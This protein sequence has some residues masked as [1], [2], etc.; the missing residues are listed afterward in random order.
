MKELGVLLAVIF[1]V[2]LGASTSY[3]VLMVWID[4]L[5]KEI[6]ELKKQLK[7]EDDE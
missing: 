1:F 3:V 6:R 5:K 7:T 4:K 2:L